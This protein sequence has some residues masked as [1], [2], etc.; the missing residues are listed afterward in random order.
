MIMYTEGFFIQIILKLKHL[1][2][3]ESY[4]I[5]LESQVLNE[6]GHNSSFACSHVS[7]LILFKILKYYIKNYSFIA[8]TKF[9]VNVA[10]IYAT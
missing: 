3:S 7:I 9:T 6:A 1:L 4:K 2:V 8:F 10:Y 5:I